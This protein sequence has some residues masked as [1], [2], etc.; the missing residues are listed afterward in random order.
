[1]KEFFPGIPMVSYE[2]SYSS[3]PFAF[4]FY[5][6][7]RIIAGKPMREHLRFALS[8]QSP[9]PVALMPGAPDP[10]RD[11]K[12]RAQALLE[13]MHKLGLSYYT[14]R[15]RDL[16][17]EAGSL[18]E[19][20]ARLDETAECLLFLQQAYAVRPL[21]VSVDLSSH[22]RYI[23]GAA[24]S[25]SADVF[26]FAAAQTKKALELAQR[27]GA[28]SFCI[29]G[30]REGGGQLFCVND[31]LA[32][33]NLAQLLRFTAEYAALLG[34]GGQLCAAPAASPALQDDA[35]W[36]DGEACL[37]FLR[38]HHLEQT[39]QICLPASAS[40]QALR[41]LLDANA[42]F[43][44]ETRG[45]ESA[46]SLVPQAALAMLALLRGGSLPAGG[47]TLYPLPAP[48]SNTPEDLCIALVQR[49]DA[50][51]LG[52]HLAQRTLLDGRLEQFLRER[53]ASYGY[54]VG[55]AVV[56]GG[57]SLT[58]LE[59]YALQ[60][61]DA[62]PASGRQEYLGAVLDSLLFRNA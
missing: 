37:A 52:L 15:D 6:Q 32:Q 34:F 3:N 20:N 17:P 33:G 61:G 27:L 8:F 1:M 12:G 47:L 46:P 55:R 39:Y 43:S 28:L 44:L 49:M 48:G 5:Q 29:P 50:Y 11:A 60:K 41:T 16:A 2:G 31:L 23:E 53:Y 19:S 59:Q 45:Q 56:E 62:S 22:P 7:D 51:A 10:I 4:K 26:A 30:E 40:P 21:T 42:L 9:L 58:S 36:R 24:T 14:L 38:R 25:P 57:A 13:L 18:R 54:G 35:Y